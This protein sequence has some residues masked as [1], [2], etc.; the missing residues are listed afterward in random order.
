MNRL[1]IRW[2][3]V[4][5]WSLVGL[6]LSTAASAQSDARSSVGEL[7]REVSG[8]HKV[9]SP[10]PPPYDDW[11]LAARPFLSIAEIRVFFSLDKDYQ[12]D[13]FIEKFWSVRDPYPETARNELKEQFEYWRRAIPEVYGSLQDARGRILM[14]HGRPS[15]LVP[16]QCAQNRPVEIWIYNQSRRLRQPFFLVFR[17]RGP[18]LPAE[19]LDPDEMVQLLGGRT[20]Q[21]SPELGEALTYVRSNADAYGQLLRQV[22]MRPRPRSEE[23]LATFQAFTTDLP[24]N[25]DPLPFEFSLEYPGRFDGRTV[26]QALLSLG[27]TSVGVGEFRGHR[28]LDFLLV[29]EV[30]REGRLFESF[31]YKF[32]VP[33]LDDLPDLIP[34]AF[35]RHLRPGSYRLILRLE[36]LNGAASG[37]METELRVPAVETRLAP[38]SHTDEETA[39]IFA[40]ATE[41]VA[42]GRPTVRIVPPGGDILAGFVRFD[43]LAVGRA[44]TR[45]RFLLDDREVM[46]KTRPPF[47][48]E[49]DLG[50]LPQLHTLR[51]E[52]LDR[53]GAIL[54]TDERW[55]NAGTNRFAVRIIE[56]QSGALHRASLQARAEIQLPEGR[57]LERLEFY[58][59]ER[60][61]A[62]L[63]QEPYIQP[64]S[65]DGNAPAYIRAVAFLADGHSTEDLVFVNTPGNL[66]EIEVQTVELFATVLNS[67]GRPVEGL[68]RET[69]RI[70]EDGVEQ[71]IKRFTWLDDVPIHAGILIDNSASMRANLEEV[72]AQAL[73][74]LSQTI[75]PKDRAAVI[76]FNRFP[77]LAVPLTSDITA[78]GGGLAGLTAEGGTSLYDSLVFSLY[79]FTGIKGKR[80]LLLLSD[81]KD[82]SS[83]FSFEETLEFARRA[84]VTVYSVGLR[85]VAGVA[86]SRLEQIAEDTGGQAFFI[87]E[88]AELE[89]VYS[90]IER[91]LRSQYLLVYQSTNNS[92]AAE[93]REIELKVRDPDLEVRTMSGYYP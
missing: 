48:V 2:W 16:V 75:T 8:T 38:P 70:F 27:G 18:H 82:E 28:S 89:A 34:L 12:R 55:I 13:A 23:W 22:L 3:E 56:P 4:I 90:T 62:T 6:T 49:I 92:E 51:A 81:G 87:Q 40:E 72:R 91:E 44:I 15:H 71:Q 20:C 79:Y 93:Y 30:L 52:A 85:L 78:L 17:Q 39:R 54:A 66:E 61:V 86:R 14:L 83:E 74:F 35:Q 46:T 9:E 67:R 25:S 69:F 29:G 11:Y 88:V 36:D 59:D 45:V 76:T 19:L 32:G 41:A 73:Q 50:E 63:Y 43:T 47:N 80:T 5:G 57:S 7:S 10:L 37:R 42:T 65:L 33:L 60:L 1:D 84:G 58:R 53:E 26:V 21:T 64:I 68:S 31:R 24:A 77:Q